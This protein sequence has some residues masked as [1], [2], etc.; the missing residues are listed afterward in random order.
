MVADTDESSHKNFKGD[1][2]VFTDDGGG[3]DFGRAL[4]RRV[5]DFGNER[6]GQLRILNFNAAGS[7]DFCS[8][9]HN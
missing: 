8:Q 7:V 4:L 2:G 3:M 9:R 5:K 6:K 1:V